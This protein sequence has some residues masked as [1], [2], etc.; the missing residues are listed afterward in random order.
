MTLADRVRHPSLGTI[1]GA[2]VIAVG[3]LIGIAPLSDNS[4]LTHLA[5]GRYI[6]EHGSVPHRDIYTF[7]A[8]GEPWVVQSWLA[9][10]LYAAVERLGG[11]QAVRVLIAGITAALAVLSWR[12]TRPAE[13]LTARVG[14]IG[15]VVVVGARYWGERPYLLGL[16]LMAVT[17]LTAEGGLD[18]RWLVPTMWLWVN[19]HG[20]FPL[21]I[22]VVVLLAVG[23]RLDG[24]QP[25]VEMRCLRWGLVGVVLAA[26][27]PIGP[28]L[29][30]FPVELLARSGSLRYIIEWQAPEFTNLA[31][32]F[33]LVE[34]VVAV[35]VLVRR[36][37]YRSALV[38]ALFLVAALLGSRNVPIASLVVVPGLAAGLRGIGSISS[39]T[40]PAP[41]AAAV[42]ALTTGTV[43]ALA[44]GLGQ[45]PYDTAGSYPVGALGWLQQ[46]GI[47]VR[48]VRTATQDFVGNY[49][50][51]THG[52]QANTFFDDR[53]DM[54]DRSLVEDYA[55][56]NGA[57]LDW[58]STLDEYRID[59]VIWERQAPLAQLIAATEDWRVIYIDEGA[60]VACRRGA[61][62]GGSLARC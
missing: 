8:G 30:L 4:F 54:F 10:V 27:N 46:N 2:A 14:V 57:D 24:E 51:A 20:S 39:D 42:V 5:T 11:A 43:L 61:A 17:L 50:E 13:T 7:T 21:G 6:L 18:P 60:L 34:V 3:C 53:V 31:D 45:R 36:P 23:R 19:V 22:A 15:L 41:G 44:V 33:F 47:D 26:V 25:D 9:S 52:A 35:I 55:A 28:R 38:L 29:L 12:L 62:V 1:A 56:L 58:E 48:E 16:L 37:R 59:L 40:R 49:L 32:R